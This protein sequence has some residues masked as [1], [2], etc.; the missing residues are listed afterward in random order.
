MKIPRIIAAVLLAIAPLRA[1]EAADKAAIVTRA[2]QMVEST[3]SG[4][5]NA[6][7]KFMHPGVVKVMGGE[8]ALKGMIANVAKDMK[9]IGLE[10]ISMDVTP[11]EK[12]YQN[13]GKTFAVVK[14]KSF[15]QI[16]GK[17][18]IT[19]ESSMIA[20]QDPT[21]GDWT[22]LRVNE[23]IASDR[24]ILKQLL[25]DLPDDLKVEAPVRPVTEPIRK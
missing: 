17:T 22:F 8:E 25:P 12:F 21:G 9:A 15:M 16:P 18:R 7:V 4:E 19:E 11:P 24:K 20:I 5:M 10:F 14:T 2:K 3:L 6:V 1:D 13:A 23:P